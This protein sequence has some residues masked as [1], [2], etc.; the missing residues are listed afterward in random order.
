MLRPVGAVLWR[1]TT[2]ISACLRRKARHMNTSQMGPKHVQCCWNH[3]I[4][5][6]WHLGERIPQTRSEQTQH[7]DS[8]HSGL[9]WNK[10]LHGDGNDRRNF[11]HSARNPREW[12]P[13]LLDFPSPHLLLSFFHS[14]LHWSVAVSTMCRPTVFT[15]SSLPSGRCEANIQLAY[16]LHPLHEARCGWVFLS[17][18]RDR[19]RC[20]GNTRGWKQMSWIPAKIENSWAKFSQKKTKILRLP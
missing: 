20:C 8:D 18:G 3:Y 9:V 6:N 17:P 13:S 1:I 15:N 5:L 19:H 12:Q 16:G 14:V 4:K 11:A 10:Q 2:I 7:I